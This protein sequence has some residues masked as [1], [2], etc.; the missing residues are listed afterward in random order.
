VIGGFMYKNAKEVMEALLA[1][2]KVRN[3]IWEKNDYLH[4]KDGK[5]L[6]NDYEENNYFQA[7][8]NYSWEEYV[9][10]PKKYYLY[11]ITSHKYGDSYIISATSKKEARQFLY[12]K[13]KR[14]VSYNIEADEDVKDILSVKFA[15]CERIK[16]Q[17]NVVLNSS[18]GLFDCEDL[19]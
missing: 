18:T 16:L 9:E 2:K 8:L 19:L 13:M 11:K 14:A 12:E 3:T 1:G 6:A 4:M 10:K 7:N 17:S 5:L 15:K